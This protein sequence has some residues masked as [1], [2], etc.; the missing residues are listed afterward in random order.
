MD[1]IF[2]AT[3]IINDTYTLTLDLWLDGET[4]LVNAMLECNEIFVACSRKAFE[5][6][7][8]ALDYFVKSLTV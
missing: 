6:F 1:K 4:V 7:D 8:D 2:T 5:T 3:V